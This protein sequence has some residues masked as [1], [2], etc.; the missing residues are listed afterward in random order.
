MNRESGTV[1]FLHRT[2]VDFL[3]T[4]EM[5]DFL[6]NK[7]PARFNVSICLL[8]VYTAVIKRSQF[9]EWVIRAEFG[10]Y[11]KCHLQVLVRNVLARAADLEGSHLSNIVMYKTLE[12]LDRIMPIKFSLAQARLMAG[13]PAEGLIREQLIKRQ[14]V[15]FLA[16]KM[17]REPNYLSGLGSPRILRIVAERNDIQELGKNTQWRSRGVEMLRIFLETQDLGPDDTQEL[18]TPGHPY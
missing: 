4:R 3:R 17:A 15:G 5:A 12:E 13:A 1:T 11:R 7:A 16:W 8:K 2:V 18:E 9:K 6:N 14:H 10:V